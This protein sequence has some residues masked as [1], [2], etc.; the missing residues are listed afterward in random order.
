MKTSIIFFVSGIGILLGLYSAFVYSQRPP[1]QPPAFTPAANPYERGIYANGIIESSQPNGSNINIYPEISG[2]ITQLCVAE[3]QTVHK[4]DPLLIV[5][6]SVQRATAAQQRAQAESARVLVEE[7][8]A[9]PRPETLRV[10]E[11]Q[12]VAAKATLKQLKDHSDKMQ[13]AYAGAQSVTLDDLDNARNAT[14]VAATNLAL[15]ERQYELTRAGAWSY[16]LRNQEMQ[17]E[18]LSKAATAAEALLAKYTL[19][20]PCDG[21]VFSVQ[22]AVGGYV[23]PQGAYGT[24]TQNFQ[25]LVTMGTVQDYLEIRCYVDE[26][27]ISQLPDRDHIVAKMFIRGT[28]ISVPIT[29]DRV[30]PYISPKIELADQRQERVDVRVLPVLFRFEKKNLNVFPGQLVDV[31]IGVGPVNTSVSGSTTSHLGTSAPVA[32]KAR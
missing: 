21:V 5:D 11:A 18:S 12:V 26:I 22:A 31:Y 15:A 32:G 3:G 16:D 27:L 2:P 14:A 7:L 6:D 1:A 19:R 10:V 13:A 20:A 9:Q 29:F 25:P 4:G 8:K 24:Y 17:Y 23:S 30:Q 28:D